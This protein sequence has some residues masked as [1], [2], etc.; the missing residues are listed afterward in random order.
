MHLSTPGRKH[1][2]RV[3]LIV[4]TLVSILAGGVCAEEVIDP[5]MRHVHDP[6]MIYSDG[7]YYVY[8]TGDTLPI[9]RSSNLYDWEYLGSVF[10]A[11]PQWI[12]DKIQDSEGIVG[13][14]WAPDVTFHNGKYYLN[15]SASLFGKNI[16]TIALASNVTLD[17]SSPDYEWVDEGEIVSSAD[18]PSVNYNTIDGTFVRDENGDMWLVFGSYWSGIKLTA[19]NNTTLKPTTSPATL[20]SLASRPSTSIEAAYITYRNGYYYLF[21][22]FDQCCNGADSTYKIMVGRSSAITG[23][24]LDRDGVDM[25]SGGGSLFVDGTSRWKGPGHATLTTVDGQDYF[26][27]HTYDGLYDGVATLRIHH[28]SWDQDLWPVLREPI[29]PSPP[30]GTIAHWNFEDGTPGAV[31]NDT[32]LVQ[33]VGTTDV[34]G[35]GFDLYA[36]DDTYGPSFSLEGQTPSGAGLSGRFNGTQDGYTIGAYLNYWSPT[37]W[38]IEAAVQLDHLNGWQTFIGR[39]GSSQGEVEADFYFQKDD[40]D[41]SFRLNLDTRGGQRYVVDG[42]FS[43]IAGQWYYLA[44]V[45][46][47]STV[48]MYADKLD[49]NGSQVVGTTALNPSNDNSLAAHGGVW[50]FGRGWFDGRLVDQISGNLD[51]IRFTDRALTPAEFL[52]YQCGQWGYL[53]YDLDFDCDVNFDDFALFASEWMGSLDTLSVFANQWLSTTQPYT[54]GAVKISP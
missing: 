25:L 16:S 43:V 45:C 33:Q 34:S 37:E 40:L 23:P 54:E 1:N 44:A 18:D 51:D 30:E 36:W 21:V 31:L 42:N 6:T 49:G 12:E 11:I 46:D 24:Y 15:Y 2:V 9:R 20:Y 4:L 41:H 5:G 50:T 7:Y 19:L 48:K 53:A 38:T 10:N 27:F 3:S 22:N 13:N 17:P 52:H 39:D 29:L 47:G 28:L 35:N 8:S 14:L 32:G 26:S